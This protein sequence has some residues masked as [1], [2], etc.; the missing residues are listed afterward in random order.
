MDILNKAGKSRITELRE[1]LKYSQ[2]D[3]A[4]K[5]GITQ[6][7]LSQI[8]SGKSNAS[9]D[10]L[11][12]ISDEFNINCNWLIKGIG[13]VSLSDVENILPDVRVTPIIQFAM[14]KDK[15]LIP[16][17]KQEAH[18][19]YIQGYEDAEY[20]KTLDVYQIPGFER[21]NY[22]LFEVVGDSMVP[23]IHPGEIVVCEFVK[24]WKSIE[25]GVLAVV[26]AK[27]GIVAKRI[28]LYEEHRASLILKSDN[29]H[30]KT[31]SVDSHDVLEVWRI[32]AK[33]TS[34]LNETDID[35]RRIERLESD[36][37]QLKAQVDELRKMNILQNGND[38][39]DGA[40]NN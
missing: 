7:A 39:V 22:R 11:K 25:N 5:I 23:T 15:A 29:S 38:G 19:G 40:G 17:V 14:M 13:E 33:I 18:A 27:E 4:E 32:K 6:G 8:E 21:G 35:S 16:L 28:F 24:D 31:Y 9:F 3:F 12:K 37:I 34:L 20:I 1:L 36:L 26:I 10:T 2:K 30:Y